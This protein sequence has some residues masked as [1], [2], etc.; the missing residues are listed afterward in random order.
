MRIYSNTSETPLNTKTPDEV[1]FAQYSNEKDINYHNYTS[2][3]IPNVSR[4]YYLQQLDPSDFEIA[5]NL[6][7]LIM[8]YTETK[9]VNL[10]ITQEKP[11]QKK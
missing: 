11:A 2:S 7:S 3:I 5:E 8:D 10:D 4:C 1:S 6:Y 9:E